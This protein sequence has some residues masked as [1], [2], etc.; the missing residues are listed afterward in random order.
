MATHTSI[1]AWEIPR[2]EELGGLQSKGLQKIGRDLGNK[3][4]Q[5]QIVSIKLCLHLKEQTKLDWYNLSI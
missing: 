4:Q 5:Q 1:L 3:Q 2:T